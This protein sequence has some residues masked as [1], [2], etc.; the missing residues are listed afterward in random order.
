MCECAFIFKRVWS[1]TCEEHDHAEGEEIDH[2]HA[3]DLQ[4]CL[5]SDLYHIL[6]YS[7]ILLNKAPIEDDSV[8]PA[9]EFMKY[10]KYEEIEGTNVGPFVEPQDMPKI[11][12]ACFIG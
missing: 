7:G 4:L 3:N 9:Q 2:V 1:V 12:Y 5:L 8:K 11:I 6:H 10:A